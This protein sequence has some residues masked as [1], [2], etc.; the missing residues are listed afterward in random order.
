MKQNNTLY[1]L[2]GIFFMLGYILIGYSLGSQW[3]WL[4]GILTT[5]LLYMLWKPWMISPF[6]GKFTR[7]KT[8][9]EEVTEWFDDIR[10]EQRKK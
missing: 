2:W 8:K 10:E 1:L 5:V 9:S 6:E 3:G 7:E 4:P